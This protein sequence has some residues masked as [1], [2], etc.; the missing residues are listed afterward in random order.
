MMDDLTLPLGTHSEV[1][2]NGS[3]SRWRNQEQRPLKESNQSRPTV[4]GEKCVWGGILLGYAL[5][6]ASSPAHRRALGRPQLRPAP[7]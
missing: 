7:S 6:P 3:A 5:S 1:N 4:D 2:L